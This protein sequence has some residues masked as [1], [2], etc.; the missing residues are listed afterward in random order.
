MN[1]AYQATLDL[2]LL[3]P[4]WIYA[5]ND[6]TIPNAIK[7]GKANDVK[8]RRKSHQTICADMVVVEAQFK[9]LQVFKVETAL[10]RYFTEQGRRVPGCAEHFFISLEEF[11]AAIKVVQRAEAA[12][13]AK[14]TELHSFL[15][16][17]DSS[18]LA[19]P[20][21][22]LPYPVKLILDA[23]LKGAD[24][25]SVRDAWSHVV[26]DRR[27]F[28]LFAREFRKLGL[29]ARLSEG[30]LL[31]DFEHNSR[32]NS[33]F[34]KTPCTDSWRKELAR[35]AGIDTKMRPVTK[36][37]WAKMTGYIPERAAA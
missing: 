31:F 25:L 23:P 4:G 32:L 20:E 22:D 17:P 6:L 7:I 34:N 37:K 18:S 12:L 1:F 19:N 24:N 3:E 14:L 33:V 28:E 13:R 10:K 8:E 35:I 2:N 21:A 30:V 5:I 15:Q 9:F 27:S 11:H 26:T 16:A 29:E 36:V